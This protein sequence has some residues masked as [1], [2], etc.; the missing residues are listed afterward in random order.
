[1]QTHK[2]KM[3]KKFLNACKVAVLS[4]LAAVSVFMMA[5]CSEADRAGN[6]DAYA[7][8]FGIYVPWWSV[9]VTLGIVVVVVIALI[10][11]GM[12]SELKK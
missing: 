7:S 6:P 2:E 10:L 1:M 5:G 9:W 3:M 11:K 4:A 8:L 12:F